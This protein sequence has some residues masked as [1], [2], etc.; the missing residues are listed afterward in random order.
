VPPPEEEIDSSQL[1]TTYADQGPAF[2]L[3]RRVSFWATYFGLNITPIEVVS[4][5]GQ[6]ASDQVASDQVASDQITSDQTALFYVVKHIFTTRDGSW[7]P[8]EQPGSI[9]VWAS[10]TYADPL[11][12]QTL[13]NT[14]N[15][16]CLFGA[17]VGPHGD[18]MPTETMQL[19]AHGLSSPQVPSK[20]SEYLNQ[21]GWHYAPF[22]VDSRYRQAVPAKEMEPSPLL[23]SY[24]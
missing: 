16:H 11:Q 14:E 10:Q 8:S 13:S 7:E 21:S 22:S 18:F 2:T 20:A 15:N 6:I 23:S 17:V 9:P 4:E 19:G 5:N 24:I 1:T 12:W 3:E